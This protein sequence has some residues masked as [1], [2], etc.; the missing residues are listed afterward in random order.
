VAHSKGIAR[1]P[2]SAAVEMA[3]G[4]EANLGVRWVHVMVASLKVGDHVTDAVCNRVPAARESI[5]MNV[6]YLSTLYCIA[7]L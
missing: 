4:A 2:R 1:R 6:H 5:V 7:L 3:D